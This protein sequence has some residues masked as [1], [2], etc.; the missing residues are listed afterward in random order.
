MKITWI[1]TLIGFAISC[2][3]LYASYWVCKT[4]SY[5]IFYEDMV[6]QTVLELVKQSALK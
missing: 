4:V 1:Y 6:Q 3:F 5:T 2:A